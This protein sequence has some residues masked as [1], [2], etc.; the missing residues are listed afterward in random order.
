MTYTVE[1]PKAGLGFLTMTSSKKLSPFWQRPTTGNGN[2]DFWAPILPFVAVRRHNQ[3]DSLHRVRH[4][5]KCLICRS[6]FDA[7]SHAF[8]DI[9]ISGFSGHFLLSV[10]FAIARDTRSSSPWSKILVLPLKF[11]WY[12]SYFRRY[13]YFRFGRPYCYFRL[14][15][16]FEITVFEIAMFC[17]LRLAVKEKQYWVFLSKRLEFL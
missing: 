8:R 13:K 2:I 12:Q 9:C 5:Q 10:I 7:M 17:S 16:L 4:G 6:Y 14:S 15:F 11:W 1:I 3:L